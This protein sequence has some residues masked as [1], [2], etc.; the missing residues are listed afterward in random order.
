MNQVTITLPRAPLPLSKC[1][2]NRK[3]G[4]R[5]ESKEYEAWKAE[6]DQY[7]NLTQGYA[8]GT[9]D[10][11]AVPGLVTVDFQIRPRRD[12]RRQDL[13][14]CLKCLGDLLTRNHV[15]EDDSRIVDLRIRWGQFDMAHEV[16]I[17]VTSLG[18]GRIAA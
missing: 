9:S 17:D 15:I 1:F 3:R 18:A 6:C 13:D 8:T 2:V 4:G 16:V 10:M 11:A 7:V 12:K 14:N 5:H